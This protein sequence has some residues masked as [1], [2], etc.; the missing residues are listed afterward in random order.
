M[1][2]YS[3]ALAINCGLAAYWMPAFA[4]MTS[5]WCAHALHLLHPKQPLASQKRKQRQQRQTENGEMIA[6]DPLEQMN[7]QPFELIGADT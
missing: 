1:I 7:P 4:G 2:Q 5:V 6:I 3:E